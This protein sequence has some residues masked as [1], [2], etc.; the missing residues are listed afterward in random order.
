MKRRRRYRKNPGTMTWLLLLGGGVGLYFLLRKDAAIYQSVCV[1]RPYGQP[2]VMRRVRSHQSRADAQSALKSCES[3]PGFI[4]SKLIDPGDEHLPEGLQ[5]F[6]V[7][8]E[9][10]E[11]VGNYEY[12]S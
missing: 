8:S 9:G 3:R 6:E 5:E 11:G 1:L 10:L 2:D 4:S 12:D 7:G